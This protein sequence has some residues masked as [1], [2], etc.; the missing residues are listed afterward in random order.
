MMAVAMYAA[1]AAKQGPGAI[2]FLGFVAVILWA[3]CRGE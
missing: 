1:E 3:M 2:I